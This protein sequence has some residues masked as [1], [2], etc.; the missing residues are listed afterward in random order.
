M[1]EYDRRTGVKHLRVRG[2]KA[3]RFCAILKA[4]G[5]NILRAAEVRK[6]RI[7]DESAQDRR[8]RGALYAFFIIK[9]RAKQALAVVYHFNRFKCICM[10]LH[11]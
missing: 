11:S 6:A 5:L 8:K 2:L 9:E 4:T 10:Q 3:V 1:S 7:E